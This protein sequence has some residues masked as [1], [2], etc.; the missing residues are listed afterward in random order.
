MNNK[1]DQAIYFIKQAK[2]NFKERS[3]KERRQAWREA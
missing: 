3:L 1:D 2:K